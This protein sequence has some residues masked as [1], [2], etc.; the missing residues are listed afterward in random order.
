M[1]TLKRKKA[2]GTWEYVDGIGSNVVDRLNGLVTNSTYKLSP[3]ANGIF[4]EIQNKRADGSL[5]LKS[6]L[7]GGT[8]P[9][10]TTRTETEYGLNGVT[11]KATRVYTL[12][13]DANG[14]L[15]S[16]VLN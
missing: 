16:E 3:D 7:S 1:S 10:Y 12:T 13:Y 11:V 15:I 14:E 8:S 6:I 2:D 4:T 5:Y 9:N